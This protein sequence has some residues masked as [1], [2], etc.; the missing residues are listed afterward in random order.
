LLQ[1]T[2]QKK[3]TGSRDLE[4]NDSTAQ[5]ITS[6]IQ[7]P[8]T[9]MRRLNRLSIEKLRTPVSGKE[10]PPFQDRWI[11]VVGAVALQL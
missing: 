1:F 4:L 3:R 11:E 5:I 10:N 9:T 7:D 6:V 2:L 8:L